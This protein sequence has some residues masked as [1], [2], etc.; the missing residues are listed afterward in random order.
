MSAA[1]AWHVPDPPAGVRRRHLVLVPDPPV[2]VATPRMRL[3]RRGRLV[4]AVLLA[5]LVLA[6]T[7]TSVAMAGTSSAPTTVT[8][9]RGQTLGEVAHRQLPTLPVR[10]AVVRFQL[11]NDLS[12]LQVQ[13]GQRLVVPD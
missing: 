13:E 6:V 1:T 3:T 7:M 8:V 2:E 11:A 5:L 4:L 9:T 10:E 12:S